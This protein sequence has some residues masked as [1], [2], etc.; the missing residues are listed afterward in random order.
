VTG[1]RAKRLLLAPL[2]LAIGCSR[3]VDAVSPDDCAARLADPD[4][5][6]TGWPTD[7]HSANSDPWLPIHHDVLTSLAPRVLILNFANAASPDDTQRAAAAQI[8]ALAEGS[9]PHGYRDAGAAPFLRYQI[10]KVVDLADHPAP[11]GWSHPS[12][13]QL[14]T[15]PAGAFDTQALFSAQFA[16]RYGFPDPAQPDRA[17]SLCELFEQGI[18][19]EL[20]IQDDEPDVRRAPLYL[21]RKQE[22]DDRGRAIADSFAAC[23]GGPGG[24]LD[25]IICGVTV[26]LAHL[27]RMRGPG[28]DLEVRGWGL[29]GMWDALPGW[30]ADADAFLNRDFD[31]R[32][33]VRFASWSAICDQSGTPCV[34][35]P[36][37]TRAAGS[38]PDGTRWTIDPFLQGCGSTMFPPNATARGAWGEATPVASRCAHFGLADGQGGQDD[39]EPYSA[40]TVADLEAAVP[41]C[42]GGW[43]VYWRQSMPGPGTAA[44]R[45]D[46]A[47]MKDWWP[48]LFY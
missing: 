7:G 42:G 28:C 17:L 23:A 2:A 6:P 20:W 29:E 47:P 4:C 16:P 35:Y 43:Q 32:F 41:D 15:T 24:C 3:I 44:H 9:R 13:T 21:E 18:V 46:G 8:A 12:S 45:I 39:Y 5:A 33:G 36:S 40:A 30:H 22:Y 31:R 1:A 27:D 10:V 19:N 26:R 38:Y 14:P 25:D 11:S 34:S 48:F 37:P